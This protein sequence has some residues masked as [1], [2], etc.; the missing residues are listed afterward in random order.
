MNAQFRECLGTPRRCWDLCVEV[1]NPIIRTLTPAFS[2]SGFSE[3]ACLRSNRSSFST[4]LCLYRQPCHLIMGRD[5]FYLFFTHKCQPLP[6]SSCSVQCTCLLCAAAV[7][8]T[9]PH[10]A[11][12]ATPQQCNKHTALMSLNHHKVQV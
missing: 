8:S 6:M 12:L 10:V 9:S 7:V 2:R 5:L 4:L 3:S 1:C 11:P